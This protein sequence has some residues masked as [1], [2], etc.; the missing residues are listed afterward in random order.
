MATDPR[1]RRPTIK[2]TE[3]LRNKLHVAVNWRNPD[4]FSFRDAFQ[5]A[6]VMAAAD[7]YAGR[8]AVPYSYA[9]RALLVAARVRQNLPGA[10]DRSARVDYADPQQTDD[11]VMRAR[12][13]MYGL[14]HF[15]PDA[16]LSFAREDGVQNVNR[17]ALHESI[18]AAFGL[19]PEPPPLTRVIANL[20]VRA[21]AT[22]KRDLWGE[23]GP[24]DADPFRTRLPK[25]NSK[26][27]LM[28][29][30]AASD[31]FVETVRRVQAGE[32]LY[33]DTNDE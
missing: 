25:N 15:A 4:P 1:R 11:I 33:V 31:L 27:P 2:G 12:C 23:T 13:E 18:L 8:G 5:I 17:A 6:D 20:A 19:M 22:E 9:Y 3:P 26:R 24:F 21:I 32:W 10:A 16:Y 29:D 14:L 28:A 30:A 7:P